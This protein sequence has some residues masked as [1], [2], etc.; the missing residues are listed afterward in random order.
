MILPYVYLL[1]NK[2]TEEFYYGYRYKN[3]MSDTKSEEDL[4]I[5]YFTSSNYINNV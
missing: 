4:G 5:K 3:V 2:E 1:V